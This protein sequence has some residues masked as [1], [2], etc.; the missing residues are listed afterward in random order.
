MVRASYC[1]R[2][3]LEFFHCESQ[4]IKLDTKWTFNTLFLFLPALGNIK[5]EET[6]EIIIQ[7]KPPHD[8]TSLPHWIWNK[9]YLL[10]WHNVDEVM[11]TYEKTPCFRKTQWLVI[12][13]YDLTKSDNLD[14]PRTAK[15]LKFSVHNCRLKCSYLFSCTSFRL[16][17][18]LPLMWHQQRN[19][20][21]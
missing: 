3:I 21:M 5:R 14:L 19:A 12:N 6:R 13:Y 20:W 9:F 1:N 7:S 10:R 16:I 11:R 2:R 15:K 17:K 18:Q 8:F 4:W